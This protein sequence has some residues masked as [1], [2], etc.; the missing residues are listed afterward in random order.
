MS[1][2]HRPG[3]AGGRRGPVGGVSA[4]SASSSAGI[5]LDRP[6][7]G[8]RRR[9]R[10]PAGGGDPAAGERQGR[11][12]SSSRPRGSSP[13]S[14]GTLNA[15]AGVDAIGPA[16]FRA[17]RSPQMARAAA[18]DELLMTIVDDD[19]RPGENHPA[20]P[21][22]GGQSCGPRHSPRLSRSGDLLQ[23]AKQVDT[24]LLR[25]YKDRR[26]R[27]GTPTLAARTE[28]YAGSS[29]SSSG[30][31]R[32]PSRPRTTWSA[33]AGHGKSPGLLDARLLAADVPA[34]PL[35]IDKKL[36]TATRALDL[37]RGARELAP[38]DPR[39]LFTQFGIELGDQPSVAAKTLE[40][41][42]SAPPRRPQGPRSPV[43]PRG[44]G[45][46]PGRGARRSE[47]A[48]KASPDLAQPQQPRRSRGRTGHVEEARGHLHQILANSPDNIFALD[49]LAQDR[50]PL[51]RPASGRAAV[52]GSHRPHP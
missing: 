19:G 36:L 40:R 33:P 50:A 49:S 29:P 45:R 42:E 47:N 38:D 6:A 44:A 46:P 16:S 9:P 13:P 35:L 12:A 39:P 24:S 8:R 2:L 43:Q 15:L 17:A 34:E 14:L 51:R 23:L 30:S 25:G 26:L 10:T 20:T 5:S 41:I 37:V 52:P 32:E 22:P 4:P 28:D 27:P 48:V 11:A 31:M 7:A 18:A 21:G 1:V 3:S